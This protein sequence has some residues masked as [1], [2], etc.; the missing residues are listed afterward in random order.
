MEGNENK[1]QFATASPDS[2]HFG[3]GLHAC[4]GRFFS[5]NEIKIVMIELLHNWVMRLKG[6]VCGIGGLDKRPE[7]RHVR[8]AISPNESAEIEFRRRRA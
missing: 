8:M 6:D 2:I 3:Y 7:S 4:P 5:S 1:H